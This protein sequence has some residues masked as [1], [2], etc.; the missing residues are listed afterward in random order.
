[1][2]DTHNG[3][4]IDIAREP[5]REA[6][7]DFFIVGLGASA[8][9]VKALKEFFAHAPATSG[10]A[11]VV[12]LHLSPDYDSKLAEVL[13]TT[14]AMP[15]TQVTGRV[16]VVPDHVYV[17]P[18]NRSLS[19]EDGHLMVSAVMG[20]EERRA[21]VDIFFRTLA[22]SRRE[23]AAC[24][25]LSGTGPDGS[26]GLKRVKERGGIALAQEPGEAEYSDMPRNAIATGLVDYVL[27]I[28]ELPARIIAYQQ[29]HRETTAQ[30]AAPDETEFFDEQSLRDI[31][32]LLRLRTR[33]DF[34]NYKRATILRRIERRVNIHGLSGLAAYSRFMREQKDEARALLKDLLISVTN[35]FR[36]RA[37]F[38]ALEQSVIPKLFEGKGPQ[39]HVRVWVAGCATGEEAYS[40]AMLLAEHVSKLAEPP[41]AQVFA[42]D[43]DEQ[44]ITAARD[45]CYTNADVAHVSPERL[46]RFFLKE[47]EGY[48]VRRELRERS[49]FGTGG[50]ARARDAR[51][52]RR[53]NRITAGR[54]HDHLRSHPR[55]GQGRQ[56]INILRSRAGRKRGRGNAG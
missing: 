36:D 38:Q 14:A 47:E 29:H 22:E 13:Q 12:I 43:I 44:A 7:D 45:G 9:G 8:G 5:A 24:V 1:M 33:H 27:P 32:T 34:A 54:G 55:R 51:R 16:R 46:R 4:E 35:F 49:R 37:A 25:V 48:R 10:M 2:T 40:I 11:Y 41:R 30:P 19:L 39:D 6:G 3:E 53:R 56:G 28:A 31:L 50:P 42:S 17:I 15:V 18:P 21:P 26:M 23:R 20:F 52:R